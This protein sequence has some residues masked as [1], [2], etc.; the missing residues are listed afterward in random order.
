MLERVTDVDIDCGTWLR[1]VN[2]GTVGQILRRI[3]AD[4]SFKLIRC[5]Y[6]QQTT[7]FKRLF[8]KHFRMDG[9]DGTGKTF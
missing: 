5:E 2:H 7:F 8:M 6:D 1:V 4:M 9:L 3:V